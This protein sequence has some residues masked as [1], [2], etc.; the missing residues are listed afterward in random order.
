MRALIAIKREGFKIIGSSSCFC[1]MEERAMRLVFHHLSYNKDSVIYN[2]FG[3]SNLEKMK[4]NI[5]LLDEIS[6]DKT[7]FLVVCI[8]CHEKIEKLLKLS[9]DEVLIIKDDYPDKVLEAYNKTRRKRGLQEVN[10]SD[11][12]K[13]KIKNDDIFYESFVKRV[14]YILSHQNL[15]KIFVE[16]VSNEGCNWGTVNI[17]E[18]QKIILKYFTSFIPESWGYSFHKGESILHMEEEEICIGYSTDMFLLDWLSG[19]GLNLRKA[20]KLC[21]DIASI[22]DSSSLR[23]LIPSLKDES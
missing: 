9:L 18:G 16:Y 21:D 7:N 12:Y 13:L 17:F 11:S 10:N 4:Y 22:L 14:N 23:M 6:R 20:Q 2:K 1:C 15:N 3:K 5:H 19:L 8:N